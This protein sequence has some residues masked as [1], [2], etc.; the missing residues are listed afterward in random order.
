[1]EYGSAIVEQVEDICDADV[2][3]LCLPTSDVVG[4]IIDSL[5]QSGRLC[6]GQIIVDCTSGNP[7]QTKLLHTT[8]LEV[9]VHLI[10]CP[11][12]GGPRG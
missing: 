8:L 4:I 2:I 7:S 9:G 5:M 10:D 11:V 3:F 1:M 12:S 6:Q